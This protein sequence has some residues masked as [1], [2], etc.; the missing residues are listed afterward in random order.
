MSFMLWVIHLLWLSILLTTHCMPRWKHNETCITN[1]GRPRSVKVRMGI[2]TGEAQ[3]VDNQYSGYTTLAA[4]QRIMSAGHGGQILISGATT[5]SYAMLFQADSELVDLGEKR[6]K[7]ILRPEHLYQ[8]KITGLPTTFPPLRTLDF[9]PNNLPVQLTSFVGRENEIAELKQE[10]DVHRLIT[11]TGSGGTGKTRLS[12]Q[13]AADLLDRFEHGVWFIE[14]APLSDPDLI[15]LTILSTIGISEQPNKTP[16]EILKEYL[17]E[18]KVLIVLDNCEH[19]VTGSA[20]VAYSLLNAAPNL[21]IL[22]S[23]REALGVKG[24]QS[25]PVPSLSLPDIKKLPAIEQLSEYEAVQT[26]H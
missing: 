5:N 18:K 21:R 14:L 15:S 4:T 23:S 13:V 25:Y 3:V 17:H 24:E 12:L 10:L 16:L 9:F 22:A 19:L 20:Q 26:L 7:D 2:H 8:V 1:H 11:L 6:L